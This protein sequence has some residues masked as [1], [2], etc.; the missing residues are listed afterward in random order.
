MNLCQSLPVRSFRPPAAAEPD[1]L[2]TEEFR[3]P[4]FA[5]GQDDPVVTAGSCFE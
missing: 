1:P 3:T 5:L 4:G 2:D